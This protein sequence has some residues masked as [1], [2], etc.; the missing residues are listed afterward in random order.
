M[1]LII[2]PLFRQ[3]I[4]GKKMSE[5][6]LIKILC[7]QVLLNKYIKIE[8]LREIYT[9]HGKN[10]KIKTDFKEILNDVRRRL[11]DVGLNAKKITMTN[12]DYVVVTIPFDSQYIT[13]NRLDE[14][15]LSLLALVSNMIETQ[16][17]KVPQSELETVFKKYISRLKSFLSADYLK[18][19]D[20]EGEYEKF[21]SVTPLGMAIILDAKENLSKIVTAATET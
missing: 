6:E 14:V 7:R 12:D 9:E 20:I 18:L 13:K 5:M 21:Y 3:L 11:D 16:G 17:G 4:K 8:Q 1:I 10:S 19:I 15:S 2:D